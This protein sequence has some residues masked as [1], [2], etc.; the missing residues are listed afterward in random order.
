[1][2]SWKVHPDIGLYFCTSSIVDW[3]PIFTESR[4]FEVISESLSY[5]RHHKGLQ[6]HAYVIMLNHLHLIISS[7]PGVTVSDHMRDFKRYTSGRLSTLLEEKNN[8][9]ALDLFKK[10]GNLM[11]L[12]ANTKFG[13]MVSILLV[14]TANHFSCK[15]WSTSIITR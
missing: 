13:R 5:C 4:F 10:P 15:N 7:N 3:Y 12:T 2:S 11:D 14:F 9:M 6:I 8:R 1:M